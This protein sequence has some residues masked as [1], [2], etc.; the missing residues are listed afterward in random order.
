[1][2]KKARAASS[3]RL[4]GAAVLAAPVLDLEVPACAALVVVHVS[5]PPSRRP[6]RS[7]ARCQ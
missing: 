4:V 1:M 3:S 6:V 7:A 5:P 2:G